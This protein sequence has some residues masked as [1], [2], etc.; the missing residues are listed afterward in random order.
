MIRRQLFL[1]LV[2]K[3]WIFCKDLKQMLEY[4]N[5]ILYIGGNDVAKGKTN[6]TSRAEIENVVNEIKHQGSKVLI[7]TP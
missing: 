6:V 7:S 3:S 4:E 5:V 1:V 2:R